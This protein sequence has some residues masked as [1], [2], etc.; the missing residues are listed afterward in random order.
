MSKHNEQ[1]FILPA[2]RVISEYPEGCKTNTIKD[3]ISEFITLNPED[4]EPMPSRSRSEA[5]YR[6]IVG[7]LISHKAQDFYKYVIV[8]KEYDEKGN[9]TNK[10]VFVLNEEGKKLASQFEKKSYFTFI[11]TTYDFDNSRPTYISENN[12]LD[13]YDSKVIAAVDKNNLQKRMNTDSKIKNTVLML[14]G[15]ICQYGKA[16]GEEHKTGLTPEGHYIA[17]AHHLIPMKAERDFFPR[18]LDRPENIVTLCP[19]CHNI[20]HYGSKE[21]KRKILEVLYKRNIKRLNDSEIYISL[22]SLIDKYY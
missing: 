9:P 20:L 1:D 3:R 11:D 17:N 19:T 7:N 13:S 16:I 4:L 22:D 2:I 8:K 15:Y 12:S 6:Q 14:D 10:N 21:E 5:S 18:S